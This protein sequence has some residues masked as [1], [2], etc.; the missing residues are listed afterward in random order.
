MEQD[1]YTPIKPNVRH[2]LNASF[3]SQLVLLK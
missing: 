2:W 3:D 1:D